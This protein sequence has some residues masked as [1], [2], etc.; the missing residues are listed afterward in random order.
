MG[1]TEPIDCRERHVAG[2]LYSNKE[3]NFY[4]VKLIS[5]IQN[6]KE[7]GTGIVYASIFQFK[8]IRQ[9]GIGILISICHCQCRKRC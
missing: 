2:I 6:K 8:L 9:Y 7:T 3:Q 1:F 4:K 5:E